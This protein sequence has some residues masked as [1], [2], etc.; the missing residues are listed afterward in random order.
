MFRQLQKTP[1]F[2]DMHVSNKVLGSNHYQPSIIRAN[3]QGAKCKVE[4]A[5]SRLFN[6]YV[7]LYV[8][9]TIYYFKHVCSNPYDPLSTTGGIAPLIPLFKAP[10]VMKPT[11]QLGYSTFMLMGYLSRFTHCCICCSELT[12]RPQMHIHFTMF[13][14]DQ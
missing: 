4:K 5:E 10:I 3:N 13:Y 8:F 12:N 2:T 9:S 1:T 6:A 11:G 14:I 7:I